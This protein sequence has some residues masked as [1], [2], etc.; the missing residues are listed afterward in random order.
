M[1]PSQVSDAINL[2]QMEKFEKLCNFRSIII[3]AVF[4]DLKTNYGLM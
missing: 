1:L 4:H 3:D 2:K